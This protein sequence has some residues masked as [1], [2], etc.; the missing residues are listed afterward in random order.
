MY[1]CWDPERYV[2]HSLH[3]EKFADEIISRLSLREG[4]EVL[5]IGC[6][7]GKAALRIA[8]CFPGARVTGIDYSA[9][10][11][12]YARSVHK[13]PNLQFLVMDAQHLS[14]S[15]QFD[16]I[17]SISCLHWIRDHEL[18]LRG[19]RNALVPGGRTFLQF[20][21]DDL[22]APVMR[23]MKEFFN[24]R[25]LLEYD[26]TI[27]FPFTFYD[28]EQYRAFVARSGLNMLRVELVQK[29][30]MYDGRDGLAAMYESVLLP[31]TR[32][33]PDMARME[34]INDMVDGIVG[35]CEGAD[36]K[37]RTNLPRLEVEVEK[38]THHLE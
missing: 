18:L 33:V 1:N 26:G 14:F 21:A 37:I 19:I 34:I 27:T 38:P 7:D 28:A 20:M 35:D 5:D 36:G 29:E 31:A 12:E 9:E 30:I 15:E 6:G 4:A 17:L 11:I 16:F 22:E 32:M 3:Q 8:S 23:G 13:L 24:D 2:A 10:M 25:R